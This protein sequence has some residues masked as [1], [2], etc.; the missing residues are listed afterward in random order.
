MQPYFLKNNNKEVIAILTSGTTSVTSRLLD[1][2]IFLYI[3]AGFVFEYTPNFEK[4]YVVSTSG[5]DELSSPIW[6]WTFSYCSLTGF[7]VR[8]LCPDTVSGYRVR[9]RLTNYSKTPSTVLARF[10]DFVS[11]YCVHIRWHRGTH[12]ALPYP[13]LPHTCRIVM[14]SMRLYH[15]TRYVT[16]SCRMLTLQFQMKHKAGQPTIKNTQQRHRKRHIQHGSAMSYNPDSRTMLRIHTTCLPN[17]LLYLFGV[18]RSQFFVN[19][20]TSPTFDYT[21]IRRTL[22]W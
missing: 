16:A 6:Y 5:T 13:P 19:T 2:Q 15:H 20:T 1:V 9:G 14:V 11:G 4:M 10:P 22:Q 3:T 21:C 7:G 17:Q 18:L 12:P 8:I